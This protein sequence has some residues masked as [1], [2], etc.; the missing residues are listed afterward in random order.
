MNGRT[1][2]RDFSVTVPISVVN[3]TTR[4]TGV[5]NITVNGTFEGDKTSGTVAMSDTLE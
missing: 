3:T 5:A 4:Q 2:Q 1:G